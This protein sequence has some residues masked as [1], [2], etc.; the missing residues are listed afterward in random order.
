M[1]SYFDFIDTK[2]L[3][4]KLKAAAF[5]FSQYLFWDTPISAINL[6]LHKK[7][8]I[9][10]VLTKGFLQDF[11]I[12]QKLY[13]QN[14]IEIALKQ[15]KVLDAKTANFCSHYFHIPKEELHVSSY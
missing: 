1:N 15:S 6:H 4:E 9:E 13:S 3:D 5:L 10:R 12:L 2:M 14:D 8:I 7:Y 11:Y